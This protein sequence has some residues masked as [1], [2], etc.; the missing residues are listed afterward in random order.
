MVVPQRSNERWSIDFV[1]DQMADGRRFRV[2][3]IVDDFSRECLGQL[4]DTSISGARLARFLSEL[5]RPLPK[6]VVCDNGPELTCKAMFF[7]S[8]DNHVK[9]HCIQP[10]KPTQNAFVESFNGRSSEGC[11]NQHWFRS[12]NQARHIIK[13]WRTYYNDVRPHSSLDFQPPAVVTRRVA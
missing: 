12:L 5:D 9:L 7:W 2:L 11:L 6:T 3:N 10:G 8:R 4:T 13:E 1:S